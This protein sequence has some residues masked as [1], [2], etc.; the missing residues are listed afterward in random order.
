[1]LYT[2]AVL[3]PM[4]PALALH[5]HLATGAGEPALAV[6]LLPIIV[7]AVLG[8]TWPGLLGTLTATV[9]TSLLAW[10]PDA[11]QSTFGHIHPWSVVLL[12][13]NGTLVS[14]LG[15]TLRRTR[16]REQAGRRAQRRALETSRESEARYRLLVDNS[17]DAVLLAAPDGRILAAN[18]AACQMFGRNEAELVALGRDAIIDAGDSRL[19]PALASC[20]RDGWYRGELCFVRADGSRFPGELVSSRFT[21]RHGQLSSSMIIRDMTEQI[22][23]VDALRGSEERYRAVVEDQ[24]EL[25]SR[26]QRDGTITYANPAYCRFFAKTETDLLGRRWQTVAVAEDLSHVESHL[27]A[28]SPNNPVVLIENRCRAGDG[29]LHWLQFVNRGFFG[30]DGRLREVQSVG[31]DITERKR[32]ETALDA[33]REQMQQV[34]E[35]QVASQ[36]AAALAHEINQPLNAAAALS[37]AAI[38]VL[39]A[40]PVERGQLEAALK[41]VA[42]EVGRAGGVLRDLLGAYRI[43][44]STMEAVSLADLVYEAVSAGNRAELGRCRLDIRAAPDLK[45]VWVNRMQIEKVLLNLVHNSTQAMSLA[46]VAEPALGITLETTDEGD[47]ALISIADNGPGVAEAMMA[48]IFEPFFTTRSRGIG[49]GLAISRALVEAHGGKLWHEPRPGPGALFLF[50]LPFAS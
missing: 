15:G 8:G 22:Q 34:L 26:F 32:M 3:L 43:G 31:R 35:W 28:L 33:L 11:G 16:Q 44:E 49:M 48:Q 9:L 30:R 6:F 14:L 10:S 38:R 5:L 42:A 4:L 1:M 27:A 36:T 17:M 29:D 23:V 40:T 24:T 37:E 20:E 13:L 7:I 45:P 46:E 25:I 12:G 41:G 47:M 39:N 21:D 50:T 19:G 18:P 2:L